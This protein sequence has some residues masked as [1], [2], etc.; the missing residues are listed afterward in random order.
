MIPD[1]HRM[2]VGLTQ[3]EATRIVTMATAEIHPIDFAAEQQ[4]QEATIFTATNKPHSSPEGENNDD[5][6]Q[7]QETVNKDDSSDKKRKAVK[8][9]PPARPRPG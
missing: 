7:H 3:T 6:N 8:A 5:A 2:F 4:R 9:T 1:L